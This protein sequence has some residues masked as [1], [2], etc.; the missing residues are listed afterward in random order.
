MDEANLSRGSEWLVT[1]SVKKKMQW[2]LG[3][4]N[5]YC[6]FIQV[7]VQLF[8]VLKGKSNRLIIIPMARAAFCQSKESL[9]ATPML[10]MPAYGGGPQLWHK[11]PQVA[12]PHSSLGAVTALVGGGL[13]PI[14]GAHQPSER[15][16]F[17]AVHTPKFTAGLLVTPFPVLCFLNQSAKGLANSIC[18]L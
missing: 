11:K 3:F 5:F 14:S 1:C 10:K 6:R 15:P 2:F 12:L 4:A 8:N 17:L 9:T 16:I 18:V 7:A 13:A